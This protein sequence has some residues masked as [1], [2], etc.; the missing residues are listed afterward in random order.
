[1]AHHK[2]A[3][4]RIRK[5][6]SE[7]AYNREYKSQLKTATRQIMEESDKSKA[8]DLL[9]QI[10]KLLDKLVHK[11]IMHKNRA[12]HKKAHMAQHVNDLP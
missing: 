5:S 2:S 10:Y 9:N 4:K 7:R 8:Q 6:A 11:N 1:M 12:A 3:I